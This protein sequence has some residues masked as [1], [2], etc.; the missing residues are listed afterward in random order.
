MHHFCGQIGGGAPIDLSNP[1]HVCGRSDGEPTRV[2][3]GSVAH[4]ALFN[5]MLTDHQISM[6]YRAY[7]TGED[8]GAGGNCLT[9]YTS[10]PGIYWA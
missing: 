7:T 5:T 3:D 4:L 10:V 9:S 1:I 2:F 8:P 6:L